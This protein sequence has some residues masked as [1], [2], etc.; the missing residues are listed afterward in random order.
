VNETL[1][2]SGLVPLEAL[3]NARPL[4]PNGLDLVEA[5]ATWAEAAEAGTEPVAE[6]RAESIAASPTAGVLVTVVAVLTVVVEADAAHG[7]D[8]GIEVVVSHENLLVPVTPQRWSPRVVVTDTDT[9]TIYRN[10]SQGCALEILPRE[11]QRVAM[12][13]MRPPNVTRSPGWITTR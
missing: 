2:G 6:A 8:S 10:S 3:R 11:Y 1:A 9:I 5:A 12:V 4:I 7:G 13:R